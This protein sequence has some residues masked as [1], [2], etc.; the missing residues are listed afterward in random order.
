MKT[1]LLV[2]LLLA[3]RAQ[4]IDC[5]KPEGSTAYGVASQ[6]AEARLSYLSKL[7]DEEGQAA[8]RWTLIWGGF[9]GLLTVAQLGVMSLFPA[10]E[11]PDTAYPFVLITGR[12]L[13]HYN[14]GTQTRRTANL[15]LQ[16]EDFVE[17]HPD[18]AAELEIV[19][20]DLVEIGSRRGAI[21]AHACV[22]RRVARGNVFLSFHFPEVKTNLL[23]SGSTDPDTR[24]PEYKVT[25]VRVARVPGTHRAPKLAAQGFRQDAHD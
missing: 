13:A 7:L 6:S 15:E 22:T 24:C 20:G 16:P 9:Y 3:T 10:N 1:W 11:Q 14:S 23:T 5:A 21:Q 4:A 2:V 8:R 19:D 18:D 25:A 12:Q 17:I